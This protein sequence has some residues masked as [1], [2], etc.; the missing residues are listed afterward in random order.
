[1][2]A[3]PYVPL[4]ISDY[5]AKAAHLSTLEH[6]AYLL[7]IMTYWQRGSALPASNERLANVARMSLADWEK[8]A[9]VLAEF[10][11]LSNGETWRHDRVEEE[12][13]VFRQKSEKARS[14]GLISAQ[15]RSNGRSASVERTFNHTDTDTDKKKKEP[16]VS[17]K[18]ELVPLPDWLPVK[19][20]ND[21][22]A[23]RGKDFTPNAR[24][25]AIGKLDA[26]RKKGHDP[27]EILNTSTMNGWKG[28]F[29]PKENKNATSRPSNKYD[30]NEALALA[31]NDP[32]YAHLRSGN[33]HPDADV[34]ALPGPGE[35][36]GQPGRR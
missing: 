10:F 31:I 32:T 35:D 28:L 19:P 12:L 33:R 27:G 17:P 15:R 20:W 7:L 22:C 8:V 34:P 2:G 26:W 13:A 1:M 36:E 25:L 29:E 14:A 4:Y 16:P 23:R 24:A 11:D 21:Y 18:G 5:L 3:I 9:P 30:P 6:G